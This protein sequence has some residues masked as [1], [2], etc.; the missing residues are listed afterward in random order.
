M[1]GQF[2]LTDEQGVRLRPQVPKACGKPRVDARRVL[3]RIIHVQRNGLGWQDALAI[4]GPHKIL[5]NRFVHW[6][7]LGRIR[8]LL[9]HPG[10]AWPSL[11]GTATPS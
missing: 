4:D 10:P 5:H 3:G 1:T 6:S 8:P 9:S 11:A 2:W 7:R